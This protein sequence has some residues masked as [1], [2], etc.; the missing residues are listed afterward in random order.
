MQWRSVLASVV[1]LLVGVGL[2]GGVPLAQAA[3]RALE[4][5]A[6]LPAISAPVMSPSGHAVAAKVDRDGETMLAIIPL[7]GSQRRIAASGKLDINWFRWVNDDWLVVGVGQSTIIDAQE[8]YVRRLLR[9]SADLKTIELVAWRGAGFSADQ[10]VWVADDGS[11]R[12]LLG[13][14]TSIYMGLGA[15]P[16]VVSVDLAT[17]KYQRVVASQNN[18]YDW[19]A[20]DT[21]QVRTGIRISDDGRSREILY[22]DGDGEKWRSLSKADTRKDKG[23]FVPAMFLKEPGKVLVFGR[24]D[25]GFRTVYEARL[26]SMHMGKPLFKRSGYDVSHMVRLPDSPTP[27]GYGVWEDTL[28]NHWFDKDIASVQ[29]SLDKAVGAE[30][31]ATIITI[32]RNRARMLVLVD[33]ASDPGRYY[34]LDRI[35]EKMVPLT[36]VND[37]FKTPLHPVR[38]I[39]YKA[40]DGLEIPAI[41]TVPKDQKSG[42]ALPLIVMPHGGPRARDTEDW[43]WWAQ[44][45]ADRGYVVVQPNYRGSTGFGSKFEE[46]GEGQ[47]GLAMQDDLN[48]AVTHLAGSGLIDPKRVCMVGGSYGGYAAMRAAHRDGDTYRCAVS[49]A[50]VSDM[51]R[52][53]RYDRRF[54][55]GGAAADFLREQAP[56]LTAVSPLNHASY[57]AMPILLVHGREDGRVPV[58][59][60]RLLAERLAKAGKPHRYVEQKKGD[61]NLSRREDRE[62]FLR[63]LEAFLKEHNPA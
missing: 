20:D 16:E 37:T 55:W 25:D 21:G 10:L 39:R 41:L 30:R 2:G 4:D 63:E 52:M 22:R 13:R 47:W 23:L 33:S 18:V 26:E 19:N 54:L 11:P 31:R 8:F 9:V 14:T 7:D 59:Q 62:E 61:H 45:L 34:V 27:V 60:S 6:K 50:G 24:D 42:R 46:A 44:F 28:R 43:D 53:L 3:P 51:A 17:G 5:F 32:S 12:I 48:D 49:F 40:R 36:W 1:G 57:M 35:E 38:T 58:A 56:D 15:F 29:Q